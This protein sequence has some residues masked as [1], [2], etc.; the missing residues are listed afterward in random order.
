MTTRPKWDNWALTTI[1][2]ARMKKLKVTDKDLTRWMSSHSYIIQSWRSGERRP[3]KP[4]CVKV[5][6]ALG[7]PLN[8]LLTLAG[9]KTVDGG[10]KY[11]QP[12]LALIKRQYWTF[13]ECGERIKDGIGEPKACAKCSIFLNNQ[14]VWRRRE[15]MRFKLRCRI[16][17]AA[18]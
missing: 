7:L 14:L 2:N 16:W 3:S 17:E 12:L 8:K 1:L 13:C 4:S 5:S 15:K 9:H 10:G 18:Q 6:K 11:S